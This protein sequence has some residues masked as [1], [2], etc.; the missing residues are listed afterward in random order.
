M[1]KIGGEE[2]QTRICPIC[3]KEYTDIPAISRLD[4][5]TIICPDC[6]TRQALE[7]L[8]ADKAEQERIIDTIHKKYK[9]GDD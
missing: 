4:N 9:G 8:G 1:G 2:R 6:G 7:S 3:G 5:V